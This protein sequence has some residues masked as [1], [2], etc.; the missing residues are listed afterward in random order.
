M[1]E[2]ELLNHYF[3]HN[4]EWMDLKRS[5]IKKMKLQIEESE[6]IKGEKPFA[7]KKTQS[8]AEVYQYA[9]LPAVYFSLF[10]ENEYEKVMHDAMPSEYYKATQYNSGSFCSGFACYVDSD[11]K[12]SGHHGDWGIPAVRVTLVVPVAPAVVAGAAVKT[13]IERI[14]F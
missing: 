1:S 2:E 12:Y 3:R 5:L 14:F 7:T 4:G 9:L 6:Q 8:E 13:V 11:S 10:Y